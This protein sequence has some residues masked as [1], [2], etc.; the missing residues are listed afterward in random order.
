MPC[1]AG[2]SAR[3]ISSRRPDTDAVY[4]VVMVFNPQNVTG[5]QLCARPLAVRA[6]PLGT[7][8][9]TSVLAADAGPWPT[10]VPLAA[11]VCRGD[12]DLAYV[13]GSVPTGDGSR[14]EPFRR[15]I[16]QFVAELFPAQNPEAVPRRPIGS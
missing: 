4:R 15:G 5:A 2:P 14:S 8:L 9:P 10:R 3:F 1:K 6:V 7:F 16:G 11:G 13:F 12:K